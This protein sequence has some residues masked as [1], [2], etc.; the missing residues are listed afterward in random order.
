[1]TDPNDLDTEDRLIVDRLRE[2]LAKWRDTVRQWSRE[3]DEAHT[4]LN[5]AGADRG[6][7]P[8]R[9][10]WLADQFTDST[11]SHRR[12]MA[13]TNAMLHTIATVAGGNIGDDLIQAVKRVVDEHNNARAL[14]D[15]AG[16][17][18]DTIPAAVAMLLQER[19]AWRARTPPAPDVVPV[20]VEWRG[21]YL[22][23]D[24]K[25]AGDVWTGIG[26]WGVTMTEARGGVVELPDEP[27]ARAVLLAL[28]GQECG[29]VEFGL[30]ESATV[31]DLIA[32]Q[33]TDLWFYVGAM[34]ED[35]ADGVPVCHQTTKDPAS[36]REWAEHGQAALTISVPS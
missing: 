6:T 18:S 10:R 29:R 14:L 20:G 5:E 2:R 9:V 36:V 19:A 21:A 11:E 31:T 13:S 33:A 26:G 17:T 28:A 24:G 25:R 7:L 3:S 30:R 4:V 12:I 27:T 23:I 8:D 15:A 22:Y 1:M 34:L 35:I 32:L 16:I